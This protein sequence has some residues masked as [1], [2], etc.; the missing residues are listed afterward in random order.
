MEEKFTVKKEVREFSVMNYHLEK[1]KDVCNEKNISAAFVVRALQVGGDPS[2]L[3]E[4]IPDNVMKCDIKDTKNC[5]ATLN[6]LL[7]YAE[8]FGKQVADDYRKIFIKAIDTRS[9]ESTN[10]TPPKSFVTEEIEE[11]RKELTSKLHDNRYYSLWLEKLIDDKHSKLNETALHSVRD[12]LD[13]ARRNIRVLMNQSTGGSMCYYQPHRCKEINDG[14]NA[15][16]VD[17]KE[18]SQFVPAL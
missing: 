8:G 18:S 6:E 9:M 17:S 7:V 14:I 5:T 12:L 3:S 10:L 1:V 4:I 16:L 2:R 11:I 15:E 13:K